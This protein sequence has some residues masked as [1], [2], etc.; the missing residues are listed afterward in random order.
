M[1][2]A[3]EPATDNFVAVLRGAQEDV[4]PGTALVVINIV[5]IV[6]VIIGIIF[7]CHHH[8]RQQ[9]I[10]SFAHYTHYITS[11]METL[12]HIYMGACFFLSNFQH[13]LIS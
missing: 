13:S 2:I 1:Y 3:A 4:I 5:I 7:C 10:D 8:H 12:D 6:V 11:P 9:N